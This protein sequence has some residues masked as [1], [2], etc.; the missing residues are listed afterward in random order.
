M[1]DNNLRHRRPIYHIRSPNFLYNVISSVGKMRKN[2]R[3][4][5]TVKKDVVHF[6]TVHDWKLIDARPR[7]SG[8]IP[9]RL[10][11]P[12][13]TCLLTSR[14]LSCASRV[15]RILQIGVH[16]CSRARIDFINIRLAQ[17]GFRRLN[18][19]IHHDPSD[20]FTLL[21]FAFRSLFY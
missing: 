17:C 21:L 8:C 10:K 13:A 16:R 9:Y 6:I 12:G 20:Y 5:A 1:L 18:T 11:V 3:F 15:G 4:Y 7:Q 2:T 19:L 14:T